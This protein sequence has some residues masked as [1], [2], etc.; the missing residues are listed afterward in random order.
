MSYHRLCRSLGINELA[1]LYLGLNICI[2][3]F[4]FLHKPN[5][6]QLIPNQVPKPEANNLTSKSLVHTQQQCTS[7]TL[8]LWLKTMLLESMKVKNRTVTG[9]NTKTMTWYMLYSSVWVIMFCGFIST[10]DPFHIKV[11]VWSVVNKNIL[12]VAA[13]TSSC[14][15]YSLGPNPTW[16]CRMHLIMCCRLVKE[17]VYKVKLTLLNNQFH[18]NL[19]EG[20]KLLTDEF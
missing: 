8:L 4:I 13:L 2:L 14:K 10:C 17:M 19:S 9:L 15:V 12:N 11:D 3:L 20:Q 6:A 16:P 18:M 7:A 1:S 5:P